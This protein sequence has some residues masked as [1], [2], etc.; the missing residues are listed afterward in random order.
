MATVGTTPVLTEK[1][2]ASVLKSCFG[3]DGVNRDPKKKME[4]FQKAAKKFNLKIKIEYKGHYDEKVVLM[5]NYDNYDE[6]GDY[7]RGM[8]IAFG[9]VD[10][11]LSFHPNW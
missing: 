2:R 5:T 3:N 11:K 10:G 8:N 1:K 6:V 7:L 9:T 4:A